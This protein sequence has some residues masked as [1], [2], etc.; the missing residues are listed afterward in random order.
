MTS[1]LQVI[2]CDLQVSANKA[3]NNCGPYM[4]NDLIVRRGQEFNLKLLFN[5]AVKAED[6]LQFTASLITGGGGGN[7]LFQYTFSDSSNSN[8]GWKAQRGQVGSTSLDVTISTAANIIIGRYGL[9]VSTNGGSRRIGECTVLFNPWNS[10]DNVYMENQAQRDEYVMSE[11]GIIYGGD[12]GSPLQ[13]PWNY[14]QFQTNILY[15]TLSLLDATLSFRRNGSEDIRKRNDPLHVTRALSAIVNSKDDQGVVQGNWSG[16][17]S[18]GTNPSAW[19]GSQSILQQWFQNRQPVKYGQCWV[20]AGVLCTVSRAL[21]IPCRII[22]NYNSAH[23]ANANLTI[24]K[25][26]DISGEPVES[27]DD[28]IWNFHCWNEGWFQRTD[29]GASYNGWQ[30]YDSTPQELSDGIFQ[31]GPTSQVAVREGEVNKQYDTSFVYSETDAD[32]IYYV[33]QQDGSKVKSKTDEGE[34]GILIC[35]KSVGSE[36]YEDVTYQYK[37]LQGSPRN[38]EVH[39]KAERLLGLGARFMPLS[40]DGNTH[41]SPAPRDQ[42]V[43]AVITVSGTPKVGEDISAT[44]ILT[45]Q[46]EKSKNVTVNICVAAVVYTNAVRRSILKQSVTVRLNPNEEKEV[47]IHIA[48]AQY[49]KAL[50]SDNMIKITAVCEVEDSGHVCLESNLTLKSPPL[51]LKAPGSVVVGKPA[52]IEVTFT[53]PLPMRVNDCVL[54]AEGSGLTEGEI[55]KSFD[56]LE[57]GKA[58]TVTLEVKPYA[59]GQKQLLASFSSDKFKVIKGFLTVNVTE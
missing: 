13:S 24:E 12:P 50:M 23:D 55:R 10:G 1:G 48:Y 3:A 58:M 8:N 45:N 6:Q 46:T 22:T 15:I 27:S 49:E 39:S 18:E 5:A 16:D 28:S 14:G 7:S 53:N 42:E 57:P 32:V 33:V 38:R 43:S 35:T 2:N 4:G 21:G 37:Y 52:A 29:L 51:T 25:Y 9:S 40:A 26:L 54:V 47:P 44:L 31:L 20:F 36:E 59:S 11:F 30:I 34:V 56:S 19:N 41:S 17:Y